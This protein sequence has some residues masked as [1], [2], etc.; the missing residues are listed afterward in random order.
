MRK[1]KGH[2]YDSGDYGM[3]KQDFRQID[4]IRSYGNV[5]CEIYRKQ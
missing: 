4:T 2:M 3:I 5:V 1:Y